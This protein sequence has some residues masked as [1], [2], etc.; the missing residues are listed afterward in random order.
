MLQVGYLEALEHLTMVSCS[1]MLGILQ[2]LSS[3]EVL[4]CPFAPLFPSHIVNDRAVAHSPLHS[5][6]EIFRRHFHAHGTL[7]TNVDFLRLGWL[8]MVAVSITLATAL[9]HKRQCP[10][11]RS[12]CNVFTCVP[13]HC[14]TILAY[15]AFMFIVAI[16][17]ELGHGELK[18]L[19]L[20]TRGI[21][22]DDSLYPST[23]SNSGRRKERRALP[24]EFCSTGRQ[25]MPMKTNYCCMALPPAF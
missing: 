8:T 16:I 23:Y 13:P 19:R 15:T 4:S 5:L 21:L 25:D 18:D 17:V 20:T 1:K 11:L 14:I 3:F 6:R 10:H 9:T 12:T 2:I 22:F 7:N 24:L